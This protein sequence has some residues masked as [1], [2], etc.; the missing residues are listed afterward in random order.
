MFIEIIIFKFLYKNFFCK[1]KKHSF[2]NIK[3]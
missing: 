1:K 2:F 3:N